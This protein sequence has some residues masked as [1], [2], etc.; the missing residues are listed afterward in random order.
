MKV[1]AVR[2]LIPRILE[3]TG[4]LIYLLETTSY[5]MQ[6]SGGRYHQLWTVTWISSKDGCN[7]RMQVVFVAAS[8]VKTSLGQTDLISPTHICYTSTETAWHP[9]RDQK[10]DELVYSLEIVVI[11][12]KDYWQRTW[13]ARKLNWTDAGIT[14][15]IKIISKL[16]QRLT[17]AREY[18]PT[19]SMSLKYFWNNFRTLSLAEIILF[20]FQ[21]WLRVK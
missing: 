17:A 3:G 12:Q 8:V 20:Q 21:T 1:H 5:W 14:F 6:Y 4:L 15:K 7:A 9:C 18:F 13:L 19:R 2:D 10:L 11:G 16:F